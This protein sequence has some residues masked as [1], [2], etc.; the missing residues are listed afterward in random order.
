MSYLGVSDIVYSNVIDNFISE[1]LKYGSSIIQFLTEK[2][3]AVLFT[4]FFVQTFFMP[5]VVDSH[6]SLLSVCNF[7]V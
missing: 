6:F 5:T 2:P 1:I 7:V 3:W 4:S